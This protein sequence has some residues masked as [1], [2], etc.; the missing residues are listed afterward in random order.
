MKNK[1]FLPWILLFLVLLGSIPLILYYKGFTSAKIIGILVVI[2][3]SVALWVWRINTR[4]TSPRNS[5]VQ[6]TTNDKHWLT[7]HIPFYKRLKKNDQTIFTDRVGIFLADVR[8]TEVG[9]EQADKE[10]QL[11][12]ASSAV[13]AFWGL[14][15][16]N[17]G[18]L[19][20]VL[21]YPTNFNKDNSLNK[22]GVVNGKVHHGG[23]MNNTMI[24]SLPALIKGFQ[25]DNDKKNVG[26]HEFSHLLDKS[27]GSIDGIPVYLGEEDK[28]I[29][30]KLMKEAMEKINADDSTI[31]SYGGTSEAEFFAVLTTYY[32]ECPHLLKVK[33]KP[34]FDFLERYFNQKNIEL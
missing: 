13:I 25:I 18:N 30:V 8:I 6:L 34:L 11:Y 16:Y 2:S 12:V 27:D 23:L 4:K 14:P 28:K 22:F 29:W 24:L 3:T 26:I 15:Y 1:M 9:K 20:E 32:K 7:Q 17:Y 31:P 5:K 10:T 21:V 33:H 19:R